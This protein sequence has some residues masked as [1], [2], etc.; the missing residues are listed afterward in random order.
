MI[1]SYAKAMCRY[2]PPSWVRIRLR[3]YYLWIVT[4]KRHH[5][6]YGMDHSYDK[7]RLCGL[8]LILPDC[9]REVFGIATDTKG[10]NGISQIR[11]IVSHADGAGAGA[12]AA[13]GR[14]FVIG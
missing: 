2:T 1:I 4:T 13:T 3:Q 14:Q 9:A 6:L 8:R 10:I 5:L 11:K 12:A 7:L